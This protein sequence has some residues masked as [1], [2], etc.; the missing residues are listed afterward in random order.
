MKADCSTLSYA[1]TGAFTKLAND[2]VA[3]A[4]AIKPFYQHPVSY[5]GLN[6][7]ITARKKFATPRKILQDVFTEQYAA[8]GLNALQQQHLGALYNENTFTI[9][10]AHQPNLFTGP[11]YFLYK[12]LH[13]IRIADDLNDKWNDKHF[14]PVFYMGSED[15]DIDEL[16]HIYTGTDKLTWH[17]Q[18]AGA[19]GRMHT[20]GIAPLIDQ[21][22][23]QFGFLPH[24]QEIVSMLRK[25]YEGSTNIAEVTFKLVNDLFAS[26]GLLVLIADHPKLKAQFIPVMQRELTEQFSSKLV[27]DTISKLGEHYKVQAAGRQ[28]NLFYLFDDGRRERI[29]KTGDRYRVLFSDLHFSAAEMIAELHTHPERFSPNVILR[30]LYQETI[31]PNIAFI[32]GGGELAY[33]LELKS[34]FEATGVPYPVQ[35][36]RNSLLLVLPKAAALQKKLGLSNAE[37]FL[38]LLEQEDLLVARLHGKLPDTETAK[39]AVAELYEKLREQAANIDDT[40]SPHVGALQAR[41]LK[42]LQG[43]EKKMQRA[44]RRKLKDESAQLEKLK[45]MLFPKDKLQER[46]E[47]MIP[48]YA[49]Y[50]AGFLQLLYENSL[51]LEQEFTVLHIND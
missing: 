11:L 41:V 18:Q 51:T 31:L 8:I 26:F 28:I 22:N 9:V 50:G 5:E 7:A 14:V 32:G 48:Y 6:T 35:I 20:D 38:S 3:G 16:N 1:E 49:Q 40:L 37:L 46:W 36:L 4:E 10:T 27:A 43:L 2:Y 24:G 13:V 19:V 47:N 45:A 42:G 39:E 23:G 34:V 33:W 21:L 12:I 30:G 15:A 29:E 44:E 17:T 25:A